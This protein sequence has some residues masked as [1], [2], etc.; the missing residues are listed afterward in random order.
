V[1]RF[2]R[3]AP[4]KTPQPPTFCEISSWSSKGDR[5]FHME[6]GNNLNI[7][8]R[9][10][11]L[12]LTVQK[13]GRYVGGELNQVV[14]DWEK[15]KIH[16]AL[17]FPD[18]YDIG[19]SNL[20][21]GILYEIINHRADALAERSYL[22]WID[23]E[24][25]MR[26]NQIPLYSLESKRPLKDFDILGISL[27]YE[28]LYSNVLN[29]LDMAAIPLNAADRKENDPIIIAGGHAAFNPEP[30][31]D[32][33]DAFVIGEGEEVIEDI[34]ELV[35][36]MKGQHIPRKGILQSMS[37][38]WGVYVPTHYTPY[39]HQD[40]TFDRMESR[41][42]APLPIKKRVVAKLP[43]PP[44]H[45]IVPSIDIVHNRIA[46][47]IMRGCTRGCRFCHAGM[48]TRPIRE[49]SVEEIMEAV[50]KS[51]SNTGY[52]ELALLSLSSSDYTHISELVERL[53]ER[54]GEK[55][56]SV[57]LPSLR[58]ETLSVDL[59]QKLSGARS[60]GFT[61]AP[62]AASESMRN[63]INKPISSQQLL[64]VVEEI[65]SRGFPT[66]KLYFMIGHPSETMEDIE[67]I[68]QL[69]KSALQVGRKTMG[70][71]ASLNI[72]AS[73]FIPKPHTPFQ[74]VACDST[75]SIRE[76]QQV[77]RRGLKIP[78]IKFNWTDVNETLLEAWLS[79]GDRRIG[80]VI[81]EAWKSGARFDAWQ[82]QFNIS[83]WEEAFRRT[84]IDPD[85]YSFRQRNL[86]EV[87]P[88]GHIS[89]GVSKKHLIKEFLLSKEGKVR[90]D[91]RESCYDCGILSSFGG[92][93]SATPGADW[94]CPERETD[95]A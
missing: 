14:K 9:I 90:P 18:I 60:S 12:L 44:A 88:W 68:I 71:R 19:V 66:I 20:G 3:A 42:N 24:E 33:I 83:A 73:T 63:L 55:K 93:R 56:L 64:A 29:A 21:L 53:V 95:P 74:W 45:P 47:E 35:M 84:G 51:L 91:C 85:F 36:N 79:R 89:T 2:W 1:W 67:Q 46:I 58:I 34:I 26:R 5:C 7:E 62:E 41:E 80:Q 94:K 40:G 6:A 52:E 77:L 39:Y 13:P 54:F 31:A 10:D 22:P 23:M 30:M 38:I 27:P 86:D 75:E 78:G 69:C 92:L 57:S 72:S 8:D 25:V 4:A 81:F 87:F 82:E 32:F 61:L 37:K 76:K 49:R 59:L 43:P 65:Y 16:V 28:T 48:V 70:K 17:L 50:E 11:R 15:V